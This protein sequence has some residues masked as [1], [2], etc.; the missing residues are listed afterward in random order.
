MQRA[1]AVS[2]Y[3]C[4]VWLYSIVR[5]YVLNGMILEEKGIKRK[6]VFRFSLQLLSETFLILGR[7]QRDTILNVHRSSSK[8]TRYYCQ[9]L[10]KLEFSQQIF[11]KYSNF[12]FRK[13]PSG[14]S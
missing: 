7:I 11:E 2:Y 6:C 10:M 1:R 8:K 5:H 4:P 12:K 14:W 13:N 9:S 3:L